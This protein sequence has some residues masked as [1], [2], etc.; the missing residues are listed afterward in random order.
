MELSCFSG[1]FI[2]QEAFA[3]FFGAFFWGINWKNILQFA[4]EL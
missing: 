2:E 1:T 3:R 4:V